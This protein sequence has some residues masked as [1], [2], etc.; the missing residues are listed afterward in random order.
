M[1]IA[2]FDEYK[3]FIEK[4]FQGEWVHP[5]IMEVNSKI[6]KGNIFILE[7]FKG[8]GKAV[9]F[10][11]D[12]LINQLEF[13]LT[14]NSQS[15][16]TH[17]TSLFNEGIAIRFIEDDV[18]LPI[19]Y[20]GIVNTTN[21]IHLS[22]NLTKGKTFRPV[23]FF[24]DISGLQWVENEA[25]RDFLI[26]KENYYYFINRTQ[27]LSLWVQTLQ[28][29]FSYSNVRKEY[30]L[31]LKTKELFLLFTNYLSEIDI[32]EN[33]S[34]N[35]TAYQLKVVFDIKSKIEAQLETKPNVQEFVYKYGIHQNLLQTIFQSTFGKTIYN[36]YTSLRIQK[37]Y[38]AIVT[39][40]FSITEVAFDFGYSSVQHFSKNFTKTYGIS[41]TDVL[42]NMEL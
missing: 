36:Y 34:D 4:L 6:A 17:H 40:K 16:F 13:D 26:Q 25:V 38:E 2:T 33:P 1:K 12:I 42:K 37:A 15:F 7:G 21:G 9:F 24:Y 20:H 3:V 41:P 18:N 10:H 11:L 29:V 31:R 19:H 27:E 22:I 30:F 23:Q 32:V 35:L 14:F 39:K 8:H 28:Q 5:T